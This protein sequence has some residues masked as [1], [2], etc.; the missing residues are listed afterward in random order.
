MIKNKK[1]LIYSIILL[2]FIHIIINYVYTLYNKMN[3]IQFIINN[4]NEKIVKIN[5]NNITFYK[6]SIINNPDFEK[7]NI[8]I[9]HAPFKSS[10]NSYYLIENLTTNYQNQYNNF[11]VF[12]ID[13]PGHGKSFKLDDF[14]YS[15]RNTA[16]YINSLIEE[17]NIDNVYLVCDGM[18]S[19]IGLNM[20][21]LNDKIF[22]NL[23]LINPI[24]KYNYLFEGIKNKVSNDLKLFPSFIKLNINKSIEDFDNYKYIYF[25]KKTSCNKYAFKMIKESFPI[26]T[27]DI[28]VDIPIYSFINK[29]TYMDSKYI[30]SLSNGFSRIIFSPSELNIKNIIK[31]RFLK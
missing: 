20:I 23:L 19:N 6:T 22:S 31:S 24:F 12:L 4:F 28:N 10:L 11:D 16:Y 29:R 30:T 5:G 18:S 2:I 15:F 26:S 7:S 25:N 9:L 17:I 1:I 14:D 21:S 3:N 27:L 8:V 13:L